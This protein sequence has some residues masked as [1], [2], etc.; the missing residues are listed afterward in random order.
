MAI[1]TQTPSRAS[2]EPASQFVYKNQIS[3]NT[4]IFTVPA[5][6]LSITCTNKSASALNVA[7]FDGATQIASIQVPANSTAPLWPGYPGALIG[8]LNVT[9]SAAADIAV[10]AA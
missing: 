3:S 7:I 5:I 9:P 8:S 4:A 2:H 10:T 6:V 1:T